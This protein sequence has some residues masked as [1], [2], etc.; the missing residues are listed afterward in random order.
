MQPSFENFGVLL[1][2]VAPRRLGKTSAIRLLGC[3]K[4]TVPL[5]EAFLFVSIPLTTRQPKERIAVIYGLCGLMICIRNRRSPWDRSH[6]RKML[7]KI[8]SG[9]L[10]NEGGLDPIVLPRNHPGENPRDGMA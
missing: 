2:D 3:R 7:G 8:R 9:R 6:L 5:P 10:T 4:D 1:F